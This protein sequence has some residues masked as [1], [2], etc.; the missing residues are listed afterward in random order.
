MMVVHGLLVSDSIS[1]SPRCST[2]QGLPN[3][4]KI[5]ILYCTV[6]QHS[7]SNAGPSCQRVWYPKQTSSR[8]RLPNANEPP[9]SGGRNVGWSDTVAPQTNGDIII[10]WRWQQHPTT[11]EV[12]V[13]ETPI[14]YESAFG[15]PSPA[16]PRPASPSLP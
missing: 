12:R 13:S 5:R 7:T 8:T 16:Q 1:K 11:R 4:R 14:L 10:F 15:S 2:E 3:S 6:L 9:L